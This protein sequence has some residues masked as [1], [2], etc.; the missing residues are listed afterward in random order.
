MVGTQMVTKGLNFENVTLVG[1]LSADQSLYASEYRAGERTFSLITQVIGRSGRFSKPGRAVIQTF[2]PENQ[3]I[4]QAARQDYDSFYDS[5]ISL[6][7]MTGSPPFSELYVLMATGEDED[8]VLRC[9][10]DI[11]R[12]ML[13]LT[14]AIPQARI[15]GPA[16][17]AVARVNKTWRYRVTVSC[18]A[19]KAIRAAVSQTLMVCNNNKKYRGVSVYA[20]FDPLD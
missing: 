9:C 18:P 12:E 3:T 19:S 16:P 15:L 8:A 2:T 6:R 5:E 7:R 1:V 10:E 11:R 4:L 13:S 14:R 20:D 17:L